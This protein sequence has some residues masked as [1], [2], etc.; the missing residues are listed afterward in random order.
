MTNSA[1]TNFHMIV[2][3]SFWPLRSNPTAPRSLP[4]RSGVGR[5]LRLQA[6]R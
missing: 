6:P 1:S 2:E 4:M 5:F 3:E